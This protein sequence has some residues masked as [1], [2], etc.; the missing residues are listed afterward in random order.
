MTLRQRQPREKDERHLRFIRSLPCCICGEDTTVEAAHIRTVSLQH[1]KRYT[2]KAERPS[3][4]WAVPLCNRHHREQH[5]MNE[6]SFWE[7]Y[8]IDPFIM[9]ISLRQK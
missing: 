9:A 4:K 8:G 6:L 3:D 7:S 1:G 2:G 5:T